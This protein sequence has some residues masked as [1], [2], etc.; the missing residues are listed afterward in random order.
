MTRT[1]DTALLRAHAVGDLEALVALYHEAAMQAEDEDCA[2]F[3][4]THAY[5]FALE[6][7]DARSD[8]LRAELVRLGR[9]SITP[10]EAAPNAA[11]I[12]QAACD[13]NGGE[14]T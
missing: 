1:L 2:G 11:W 4:L 5:V 9:D 14:R 3:Y 7:G 6:R 10:P 8:L 12:G 13:T